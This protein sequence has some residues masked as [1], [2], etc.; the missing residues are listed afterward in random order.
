LAHLGPAGSEDEAMAFLEGLRRRYHDATHHCWAY[1]LGWAESL[2]SRCSDDGEPS[3]TAGTPILGAL[4]ERG[5]SDAC[6]VVVR[7]FGGVKLGTGGLARAYRAAARSVLEEADLRL[8]VLCEETEVVL[9]YGAQGSLRHACAQMGVQLSEEGYGDKL[10]LSAR[11]PRAV[12][13]PFLS[14]LEKLRDAWKG[15]VRWRSK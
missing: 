1:R 3:Y 9:P 14:T 11:V 4:E 8:E 15:E 12:H 2:R 13:E 10:T 6:I 5:A 7:Y